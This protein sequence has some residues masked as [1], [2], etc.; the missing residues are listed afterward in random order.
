MVVRTGQQTIIFG[1]TDEVPSVN[2]GC[3]GRAMKLLRFFCWCVVCLAVVA[4]SKVGKAQ[5]AV[6][7]Q[8]ALLNRPAEPAPPPPPIFLR[9]VL[10]RLRFEPQAGDNAEQVQERKQQI[11]EGLLRAI[12][13]APYVFV[14]TADDLQQ[15]KESGASGKLIEA[16][17]QANANI[18]EADA[19]GITP[20][21]RQLIKQ[22]G[23][24]NVNVRAK[25]AQMLARR[26]V[27]AAIPGFAVLIA[28]DLWETGAAL[29]REGAPGEY[30]F[31]SY[32][33]ASR[34]IALFALL[35]LDRPAC[36][37]ALLKAM[38]SAEPKVRRWAT[39]AIAQI[40]EKSAVEEPQ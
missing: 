13:A 37:R 7:L 32:L 21:D 22:L 6:A 24:K 15:L 9:T 27:K 8:Q 34:E 11:E 23:Q 10:E 12:D 2:A 14:P 28:S 25:A 1:E 4:G 39:D 5:S 19:S 17:Q 3:K 26:K 38:D 33:D 40:V 29:P 18:N 20:L 35:E 30:E 16:L 31:Y 36:E